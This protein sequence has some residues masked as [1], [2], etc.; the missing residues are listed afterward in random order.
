MGQD[1]S[2]SQRTQNQTT[3]LSAQQIVRGFE[4]ALNAARLFEGATAPNPAVGCALFDKA[5]H[6]LALAAH[7]RAGGLHAEAS[8][9]QFCK[10]QGTL[11]DIHTAIVTLEPCNHTGR[12]PACCDALLATS[13]QEIWI[14]SLDPNRHVQGGGATRL[15]NSG[16]DVFFLNSL[17]GLDT[18]DLCRRLDRLIAPFVKHS[19]TGL[20]WVTVKQALTVDGSMI[21]P[22]GDKTFTSEVSLDLAHSLRRRADAI[23]TGSGTVLADNP[24]FTVR[25]VSDFI[26]KKRSLAIL[27]RRARVTAAYVVAAE[28]RGFDVVI[29]TSI[30][31]LLRA[32]GDAGALEVLVE[33]GPLVTQ[34]ILDTEFWDEHIVIQQSNQSQAL[35]T[36]T[37][38]QRDGSSSLVG[39]KE[40]YVLR[41]H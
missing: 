17:Q 31:T 35:D 20:P 19:G 6:R 8:A 29:G 32:L 38:Y 39:G 23:V 34:S 33:A 9:L 37:V 24:L 16:R 1:V 5:G 12:T 27:D 21:P 15:K 18:N 25:R 11:K 2:T 41:D 3:Q 13:V 14:G 26:H 40:K 4:D 22:P 36:T 10:E 28:E 30:D 7:Q